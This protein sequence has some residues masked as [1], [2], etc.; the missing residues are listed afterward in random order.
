MNSTAR[1]AALLASQPAPVVFLDT[2]AILD[3]VRA[4]ALNQSKDIPAAEA[5][6]EHASAVPPR[7]HLVK[8]DIVDDEWKHNLPAAKQAAWRVVEEFVKLDAAA[9]EAG[10]EEFPFRPAWDVFLDH[11]EQLS[12]ALLDHCKPIE[13]D[14]EAL[15]LAMARVVDRRH[16]SR[17][18]KIK[19]AYIVEHCLAVAREL[20]EVSFT[21]PCFFV[22]SNVK[23]FTAE[24]KAAI[25]PD[26]RAEFDAAALQYSVTIGSA[27][28]LLFRPRRL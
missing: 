28:G 23:D 7:V 15:K 8:A 9:T 25:H 12:R 24:A 5:L 26:M 14:S 20:R 21:L 22:S 27:F 6:I 16:P 19:D 4:P 13:R 2:C 17:D 10:L 1:F 11:L 18:G 3:I